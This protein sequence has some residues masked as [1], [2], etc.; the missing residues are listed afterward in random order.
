MSILTRLKITLFKTSKEFLSES[1]VSPKLFKAIPNKSEKT[2][3]CSMLPSA[4]AAMGL[5]GKIFITTSFREGAA[6]DSNAVGKAK[7]MPIPGLKISAKV[8]AIEIAIAVVN[9]YKDN[10]F[11]LIVPI[12]EVEEIETTPQTSEK[13]TRGTMTNLREAINIWP[14]ISNRPS[15]KNSIKIKCP[16]SP[17]RPISL[18]NFNNIPPTIAKAMDKIILEVR[19]II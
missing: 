9:K 17:K 1:P 10:V 15:V 6:V 18:I 14:T 13:K 5:V 12:L 16:S 11:K 19:L 8:R 3:I 4:I 2:I 7:S